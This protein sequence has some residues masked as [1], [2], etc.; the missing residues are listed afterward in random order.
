VVQ[1]REFSIGERFEDK[2]QAAVELN[3]IFGGDAGISLTPVSDG[4]FE[5]PLDGEDLLN[6]RSNR[7]VTISIAALHDLKIRIHEQLEKI[8]VSG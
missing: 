2:A 3:N 8:T 6:N 1:K 4:R 7:L 5:V